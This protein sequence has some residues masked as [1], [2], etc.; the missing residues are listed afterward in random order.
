MTAWGKFHKLALLGFGLY[1]LSLAQA[2]GMSAIYE[3]YDGRTRTAMATS[4]RKD[5]AERKERERKE[6]EKKQTSIR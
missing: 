3:W 1:L 4:M 6:Q 2:A 5:I